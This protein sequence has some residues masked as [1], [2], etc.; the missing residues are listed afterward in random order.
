[1]VLKAIGKYIDTTP[2]ADLFSQ[3]E[4]QMDMVIFEVDRYYEGLDLADFHFVMRGV[5]ESGGETTSVLGK[6]TEGDVLHLHWIVDNTFTAE[7]G[8]LS[9]DLF[10][11]LYAQGANPAQDAPTHVL[12]YQLAPVQVRALPESDTLLE[13]HSYTDFLLQVKAAANDA[14]AAIEAK[15]RDFEI[16]YGQRFDIL[17]DDVI[18]NRTFLE[19]LTPIVTLTQAEYD[20]L[21]APREG[22]LYLIK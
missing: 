1:M 21:D 12:R 10:G 7:G 15:I 5:T 22:T 2:I 11:S 17:E 13:S 9:L 4:T 8:R 18:A 19:E 16:N 6:K 3:E 20:A 14:I